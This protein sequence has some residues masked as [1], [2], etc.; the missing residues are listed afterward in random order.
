MCQDFEALRDVLALL[1]GIRGITRDVLSKVTIGKIVNRLTKCEETDIASTATGLVA[2]WKEVLVDGQRS[3]RSD[4]S[5]DAA[6]LRAQS[7]SSSI[8]P[9]PIPSCVPTTP[10]ARAATTTAAVTAMGTATA[11]A[12]KS[13]SL[14]NSTIPGPSRGSSPPYSYL[15][16]DDAV[17]SQSQRESRSQIIASSVSPSPPRKESPPPATRA[18]LSEC[19][20]TGISRL[21]FL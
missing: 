6:S 21:L 5:H 17:A 8:P 10:H 19:F 4:K 14:A 15:R 12:G 9:D 11:V 2:K 18:A 13:S 7:A 16:F 1:S 3:D 20:P